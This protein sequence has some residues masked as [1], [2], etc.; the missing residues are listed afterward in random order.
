MRLQDATE[1][2]TY[3]ERHFRE[4]N[5][6]REDAHRGSFLLNDNLLSLLFLVQSDLNEHLIKD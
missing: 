4:W 5:P 6:A 1:Q 2:A 3:A